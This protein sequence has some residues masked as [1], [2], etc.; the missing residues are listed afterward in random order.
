M[1]AIIGSALSVQKTQTL[2]S[3]KN[4]FVAI[5]PAQRARIGWQV[6]ITAKKRATRGVGHASFLA[7]DGVNLG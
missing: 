7:S 4:W 3:Q 1:L 2:G 6:S 5:L